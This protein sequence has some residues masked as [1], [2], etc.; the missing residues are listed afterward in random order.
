MPRMPRAYR[1]E[2]EPRKVRDYLLDE[3]HD[4]GGTKALFFAGYGF[5][6]QH[7]E[8]LAQALLEH[9]RENPAYLSQV[10][11]DQEKWLVEGAIRAPNGAW[12]LVRS[13]W[14][15]KNTGKPRLLSAYRISKVKHGLS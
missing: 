12:P 1:A 5:R 14:A 7:W 6:R 2:I 15:L 9:A 13:V 10:I 4:E 8:I 3:D 11:D